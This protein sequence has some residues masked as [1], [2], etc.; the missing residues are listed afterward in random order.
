MSGSSVDLVPVR[1]SVAGKVG[2]KPW[3]S[4][5]EPPVAGVHPSPPAHALQLSKRLG[6]RVQLLQNTYFFSSIILLKLPIDKFGC[7]KSFTVNK[8][9]TV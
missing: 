9:Q 2:F 4:I 6:D 5:S 7:V 1:T 8:L 3:A